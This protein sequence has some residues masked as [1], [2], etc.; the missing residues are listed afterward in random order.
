MPGGE[1]VDHGKHVVLQEDEQRS[2]RV[3]ILAIRGFHG[4]KSDS[5]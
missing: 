1:S 4:L 5:D 2:S 3:P